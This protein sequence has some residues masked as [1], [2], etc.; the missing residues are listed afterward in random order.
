MRSSLRRFQPTRDELIDGLFSVI[1]VVVALV[2]FRSA[3]GGIEFLIVGGV[4]AIF[5]VLTGYVLIKG[6]IS[7]FPSM[8]IVLGVFIVVAG[9][10]ALRQEALLS[11]VPTPSS[12]IALVDGVTRGWAR[13]LTTATPTGAIDQLMVIPYAVGFFGG[14]NSFVLARFTKRPL[15]VIVP[16]LIIVIVSILFG[17]KDPASVVV[18]GGVYLILA[19][20]WM[21]TRRERTRGL[22]M[23]G[24]SRRSRWVGVTVMLVVIAAGAT[25]L[26][27]LVPLAHARARLVLR[28]EIEPPFD[29]RDYSSPLGAF[30]KFRVDMADETLFV[31]DGIPEDGARV[32]LAVMDDYDGVV[33][34]VGGGGR[35]G[36]GYFERVGETVAESQGADPFTAV[37][38][39]GQLTGVWIP[40]LGAT[41]R[42]EFDGDRSEDLAASF[43]FNRIS[44]TAAAPIGLDSG[45]Y[46]R[47]TESPPAPLDR[48]SLRSVPVD[49]SVVFDEVVGMPSEFT[50]AA[51]DIVAGASNPY[52]QAHALEQ[53]FQ[54][55]AYS[56]GGPGVV[57]PVPPGHS[58]GRIAAFVEGDQP[59]GDGEQYAAT[60]ALMA[61][62]L[63]LPARVVVGYDA[64][65]GSGPVAV[66]GEDIDA[67]VEIA[68][69]GVGWV[70]F[71]P[72]P[73]ESNAPREEVQEQ[74]QKAQVETQV[75]PPISNPP[76]VPEPVLEDLDDV[77]ESP[78]EPPPEPEA[79]VVGWIRFAS[80]GVAIPV[81][82]GVVFL[83]IV[84]ALKKRRTR[85]R[86]GRGSPATRISAGWIEL[87]DLAR[88]QRRVL[89]DNAT[90]V[91]TAAMIGGGA[92]SL[93]R[94]ADT[95]VFGR[96][97]P[98]GGEA[99]AFWID[100]YG[101]KREMS[102]D[103]GI[104]ASIRSVSSTRSLRKRKR[105]R[106]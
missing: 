28:D 90:R 31:V 66:L 26:G 45:D 72:T 7:I 81:V 5:G 61:R 38:E 98:S 6:K 25:L 1:L 70:P 99:A 77:E 97:D 64:Q 13:L 48:E 15:L 17:T 54:Q 67:W 100:V 65:P 68:F 105:K 78:V 55:G 41:T 4:A 52:D 40:T 69:D 53:H 82:A 24:S 3:Y 58:I 63:N 57:P 73:D 103:R 8:A 51:A 50:A 87:M 10:L 88:D 29:P 12:F 101:V 96:T 37:I 80:I 16:S 30:R 56:D 42:L 36:A 19:L 35:D 2:G 43:R 34:N 46:Y 75:P 89:I 71:F 33:W 14:L 74:K 9:P 93:A 20:L 49:K 39:I 22:P 59:V 83:G 95:D 32:Q 60:M 76:F 91:E 44:R 11:F 62:A 102:S 106:K 27:P 92:I 23:G 18:Q 104:W 84:W 21:S 47:V 79:E 85:R 94:R 86:R